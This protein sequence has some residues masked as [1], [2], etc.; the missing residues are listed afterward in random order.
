MS[1]TKT[2]GAD[3]G[4]LLGYDRA[5]ECSPGQQRFCFTGSI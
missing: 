4:M 2:F 3:E 5:G 1:F